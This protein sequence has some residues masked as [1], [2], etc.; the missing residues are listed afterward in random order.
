MTVSRRSH[1]GLVV[2]V[3]YA[4][5]R[6][7]TVRAAAAYLLVWALIA[8]ASRLGVSALGLDVAPPGSASLDTIAVLLML[9]PA[10]ILGRSLG[11]KA[12]SLEP[13]RSR[14]RHPAQILWVAAIGAFA[15][16]GPLM[17]EPLLDESIGRET[18][19][20][21]WCSTFGVWLILTAFI[22]QLWVTAFAFATLALF[23][24]PGLVP[25]QCNI[26]YNLETRSVAA[27]IGATLVTAGL[28]LSAIR[29]S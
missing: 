17:T 9:L 24:T 11:S 2:V 23:S 16:L 29:D 25:W 26:I 3:A 4:T 15:A 22:P 10:A 20:T 13:T 1:P 28:L 21:A 12:D 18:F 5:A 27:S 6:G 7:F 8:A 14:G 19:Y